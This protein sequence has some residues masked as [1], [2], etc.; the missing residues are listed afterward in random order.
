MKNIDIFYFSGTGNSLW[1][2]KKIADELNGQLISANSQKESSVIN[3]EAEI[4]G[5]I[6]PLYDF[7]PPVIIEEIIDKIYNIESKYIFAVCTYG[8][9]PAKS[10]LKIEEKIKN[11][12]GKLAGGF[13][14]EMPHSGIGSQNI[15]LLDQNRILKQSA[16]KVDNIY[17]YIKIKNYG[18]IETGNIVTTFFKWKNLKMLPALFKLIFLITFKGINTLDYQID[19]NCNSCGICE[20]ICPVDNI[21]LKKDNPVWGEK[22]IGCF[23]CIQWCPQ[24]SISLGG[25]ELFIKH[26]HHPEIKV[27]EMINN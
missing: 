7:K 16:E 22:C 14:V 1:I 19:Q 18:V 17:N 21:K 25:N 24:E 15:S 10:L 4:I 26:Y 20:K 23:G 9:S 11:K 6:F 2:A 12:D 5:L 27:S 3:T 13:A 8:I